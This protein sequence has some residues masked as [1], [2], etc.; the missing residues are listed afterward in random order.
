M[1]GGVGLYLDGQFFARTTTTRIAYALSDRRALN[2]LRLR[3]PVALGIIDAETAQYLDD[4]RVLGPLRNRLLAGQVPDLVDRADHL[5]VDRVVQHALDEAA[6][7]LEEIDREMLQVAERREAG[8]EVVERELAAE[9]LEGLD[10][11]AR[12]REVR[13]GRCLGD[14]EADLAAVYATAV[15]LLDHVRQELVVAETLARQVD[16]AHRESPALVGLGHQPAECAVDHPAVDRRRD[17]VALRRGDE[18]VGRDDLAALVAHAQQQLEVLA[19]VLLLQR[20]YG[21]AEQLEARLLERV[22]DARGPLHLAAPA[23]Q[24]DVVFLEA[25]HAVAARFLG[26]AAGGIGRG[27]HGRHV[28]VLGGDRHDADR[29]AEAEAAVLPGVAE[30]PDRLAQRLC[31]AQRLLQRAALEQHSE[32]VAAKARERVAPAHLGLQQGADLPEQRIPGAVAAGVVDDLELV[33][34]DEIGRA[35]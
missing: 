10:E 6:V 27:Q 19:G 4:L 2:A 20:Q 8:A 26:G 17:A 22:V 33:D 1:F 12:L 32:L 31:R 11:A 18:L 30:V 13:D 23:H 24:V 9:L 5:A 28:L 29:A 3:H 16:R 35:S 34:V 21:H 15:E 14:L 7:D 25:V